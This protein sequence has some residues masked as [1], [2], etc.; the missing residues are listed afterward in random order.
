MATVRRNNSSII[1]NSSE[2][3]EL[4]LTLI[5]LPEAKLAAGSTERGLITEGSASHSAVRN[6]GNHKETCSLRAKSSVG[7]TS[8]YEIFKI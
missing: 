2:S 4:I 3:P 6:S 5:L 7:E 8:S 1:K